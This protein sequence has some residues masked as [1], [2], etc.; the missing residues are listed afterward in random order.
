[1]G[2]L[3]ADYIEECILDCV[4]CGLD[5]EDMRTARMKQTAATTASNAVVWVESG[6]L[7]QALFSL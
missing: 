5:T 4:N 1:V 7:K 6:H 3:E 2:D